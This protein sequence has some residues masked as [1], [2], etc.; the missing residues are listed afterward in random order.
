MKKLVKAI[1]LISATMVDTLSD[2]AILKALSEDADAGTYDK[3]MEQHRV[4]CNDLGF[5]RH[6]LEKMASGVTDECSCKAPSKT[7]PDLDDMIGALITGI[8]A[9]RSQETKIPPENKAQTAV[10]DIGLRAGP[11]GAGQTFNPEGSS[12]GGGAA[13]F[14][15]AEMRAMKMAHERDEEIRNLARREDQ[16]VH[17]ND[18]A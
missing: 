17:G 4:F 14:R 16:K 11:G 6:Q 15:S 12:V 10:H 5:I 1:H 9:Q 7:G 18:G 8:F 3:D 13:D 2:L